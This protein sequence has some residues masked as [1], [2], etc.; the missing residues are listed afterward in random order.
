MI[1]FYCLLLLAN[2][3][4]LVNWNSKMNVGNRNC[5]TIYLYIAN[6]IWNKIIATFFPQNIADRKVMT[7]YNEFV[8]IIKHL[9]N[10]K[11]NSFNTFILKRYYA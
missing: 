8:H 7:K 11:N 9:I 4:R 10:N 3:Y 2:T 1:P 6:I 5:P